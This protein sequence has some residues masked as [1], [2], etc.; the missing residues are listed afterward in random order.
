MYFHYIAFESKDKKLFKQIQ[1]HIGSL[2][3]EFLNAH[4]F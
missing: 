1:D 3:Y 4:I 2:D